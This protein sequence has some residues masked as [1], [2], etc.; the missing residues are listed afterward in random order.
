MPSMRRA[1]PEA[2]RMELMQRKLEDMA[3]SLKGL[4]EV[5]DDLEADV[6]E[7]HKV[8]QLAAPH[9]PALGACAVVSD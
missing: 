4:A 3:L 9:Q 7:S 6:D 8:R 1:D 5:A 2:L